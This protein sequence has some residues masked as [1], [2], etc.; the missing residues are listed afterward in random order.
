MLGNSLGKFYCEI[1]YII[2]LIIYQST[3]CQNCH[4]NSTCLISV[5]TTMI[6]VSTSRV[7][8]SLPEL[9]TLL[10][11]LISFVSD[12][13]SDRVYMFLGFSLQHNFFQC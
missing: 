8:T 6:Y 10:R 5:T 13:D 3:N 12:E 1:K 9:L 2:Y 4:V 11:I 7:T